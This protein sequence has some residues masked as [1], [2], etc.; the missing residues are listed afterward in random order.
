MAAY[1]TLSEVRN[2]LAALN[3]EDSAPT[4][5]SAST[6][7]R[8]I[9][10]V[11]RDIYSRFRWSWRRT[12]TSLAFS[13]TTASLP[14]D[15]VEDSYGD[16]RE[17]LSGLGNDNTYR[18]IEEK[19]KDNYSNGDYVCWITGNRVDGF[20]LN[21]HE[22]DNPTLTV[23]Y[24]AGF[25]TDVSTD[26]DTIKVPNAMVI[27]KGAYAFLKRYDD[28]EIDIT[29]ELGDYEGDITKLRAAE[30][31]TDAYR[32]RRLRSQ[33]EKTGYHIGMVE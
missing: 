15:W 7:D 13:G 23:V 4:T 21:I 26:G 16:I 14:S 9:N 6:R 2:L 25:T 1:T 8:F 32:T 28:P 5:G 11:L 30:F 17:V 10:Q 3:G 31:R 22:T 29:P 20:T 19:F 18:V 24:Y 12:S 27:A 33:A